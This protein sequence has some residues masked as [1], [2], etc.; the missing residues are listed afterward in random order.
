M[1]IFSVGKEVATNHVTR[2]SDHN[3]SSAFSREGHVKPS[4]YGT[5]ICMQDGNI[6]TSNA[7][8]SSLKE[9]KSQLLLH[10]F[11]KSPSESHHNF[12]FIV[13]LTLIPIWGQVTL[14]TSVL[15][16]VPTTLPAII[17]SV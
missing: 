17:F 9:E 5:S 6:T 2:C 12:S 13:L 7:Y 15:Q 14:E 3:T 8:H 11:L 10:H 1:H 4:V 16:N